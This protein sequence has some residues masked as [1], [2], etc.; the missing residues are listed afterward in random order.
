MLPYE[1]ASLSRQVFSFHERNG[2][3]SKQIRNTV[4]PGYLLKDTKFLVCNSSG[5][6]EGDGQLGLR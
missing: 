2:H 6:N 5:E 4:L 1:W 3:T